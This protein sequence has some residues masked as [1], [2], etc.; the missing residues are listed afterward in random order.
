MTLLPWY[1]LVTCYCSSKYHNTA[2]SL[3]L[4]PFWYISWLLSC[5]I[6]SALVYKTSASHVWSLVWPL[7]SIEAPLQNYTVGPLPLTNRPLWPWHPEHHKHC[8]MSPS[9]SAHLG[10][11][12]LP[13]PCGCRS[14]HNRTILQRV[15]CFSYIVD[16]RYRT[17]GVHKWG[18]VTMDGISLV[19]VQR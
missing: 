4:F 16:D 2:S 12:H 17:K 8:L 1:G 19:G 18:S 13:G 10:S 15:W 11:A 3:T 6:V 5:A 14:Y 9:S 7:E